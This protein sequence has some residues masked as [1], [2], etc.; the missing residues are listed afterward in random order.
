MAR[1]RRSSGSGWLVWLGLALV[2][3]L[4]GRS[5]WSSAE[6][7]RSPTSPAPEVSRGQPNEAGESRPSS[8]APPTTPPEPR[9]PTVA[10][11]PQSVWAS[12]AACEAALPAIVSMPRNSALRVASWN[13]H[14]FPYGTKNNVSKAG[15]TDVAWMACAMASMR[16]DV[17]AVQEVMTSFPGRS[18]LGRLLDRLDRLT[19][20]H[21]ESYV[22]A[23]PGDRRQHVGFLYDSGR[24]QVDQLREVPELNAYGSACAKGLRPGVAARVRAGTHEIELVTLHFDSGGE[25][26]DYSHRLQSVRT[27]TRLFAS[28]AHRQVLALGDF[29]TMGC[30]RCVP[31]IGVDQELA[32]LSRILDEAGYRGV[33]S[34]GAQPMCSHHFDGRAQLLDRAITTLPEED[35]RLH[36]AGLCAE[37]ACQRPR[38]TSDALERLSDHCPVVVEIAAP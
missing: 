28:H 8:T 26:R 24:V 11:D 10:I 38:T 3:W 16:V 25:A 15:G 2:F 9:T 7:T 14:W 5:F 34:T 36:P 32:E 21:W 35:V 19:K 20:G 27:L 6:S 22:D 31:P 23:C 33:V 12:A 17:I 18:A 4:S 29:N 30:E 37:L 13:L 1:R